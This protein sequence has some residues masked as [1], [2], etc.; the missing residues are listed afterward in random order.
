MLLSEKLLKEE[1]AHLES[2]RLLRVQLTA[3]DNWA[4]GDNADFA[5][6][7]RDSSDLYFQS[8]RLRLLF[9]WCKIVCRL[10]GLKVRM[11][12]HLITRLKKNHWNS[13]TENAKK[14]KEVDKPMG[15]KYNILSCFQVSN[16]CLNPFI[17]SD[18]EFHC[19]LLGRSCTLLP[20]SPLSP[21]TTPPV[22]CQRTNK[23]DLQSGGTRHE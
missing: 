19:L 4:D 11:R 23:S 20:T 17:I 18:R 16:H 2:T 9:K 6:K 21:F 12:I 5:G 8:D 13:R 3:A 1:I 10:Y 22:T 7:R 14:R 15:G